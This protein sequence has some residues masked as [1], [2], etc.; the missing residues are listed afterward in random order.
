MPGLKGK[1]NA[2]CDLLEIKRVL[3]SLSR[4]FVPAK[5]VQKGLNP[6]DITRMG[7]SWKGYLK[8]L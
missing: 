8:G 3:A 6:L 1:G 7:M 5:S 4:Y 2:L